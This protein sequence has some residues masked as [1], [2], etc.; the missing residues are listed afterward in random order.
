[1]KILKAAPVPYELRL[2]VLAKEGDKFCVGRV[3]PDMDWEHHVQQFATYK[4]AERFFQQKCLILGTQ[5]SKMDWE[6][7]NAEK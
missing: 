7:F 3:L 5:E 6:S 2:I 1:M 4:E